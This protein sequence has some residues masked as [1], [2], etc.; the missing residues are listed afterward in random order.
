MRLKIAG[1]GRG[2][3]LVYASYMS[4]SG[5]VGRRKCINFRMELLVRRSTVRF[6]SINHCDTAF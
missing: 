1:G 6:A 5:E 4:R 2:G 3:V